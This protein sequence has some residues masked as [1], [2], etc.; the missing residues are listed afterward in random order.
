MRGKMTCFIIGPT[1]TGKTE[2]ALAL[3]RIV[4]GEV[5]SADSMQIYRHMDIGTAKPPAGARREIPHHMID[6]A[7]PDAD[8]SVA[9]YQ[10]LATAAIESARQ[11]GMVPIVAGGTGLYVNSLLYPDAYA[12]GEGPVDFAYRR[13]LTETAE[14]MGGQ[15]MHEALA[16]ICP[17]A[18]RGVHPN[19]VRRVI[20]LLERARAGEQ[21]G[22]GGRVDRTPLKNAITFILSMER[23]RLYETIDRRVDG[24]LEQGLI[25]EVGRLLSMG[26]GRELNSM[27]GLGYRETA[28]YLSGETS[29]GQAVSDIKK[30]TRNFAKRQLTWFNGQCGGK[31][32]Y[33]DECP[34]Q[35]II[36]QTILSEGVV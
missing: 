1:A 20:R 21:G 27:R 9:E 32:I 33:V 8:F 3:A 13:E 17:E 16:R 22:A 18:A 2:A 11:R 31:W 24:M 14:R 23:G 28:S 19:N 29:Y 25:G 6:I 36:I 7:D 10:S 4:G 30:N 26:Y 12:F 35:D 34:P 15:H 5:I